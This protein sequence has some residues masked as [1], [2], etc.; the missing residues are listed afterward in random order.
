MELTKR[1]LII[2]VGAMEASSIIIGQQLNWWALPTKYGIGVGF[3]LVL[4][5]TIAYFI[6][7]KWIVK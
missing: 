7:A 2:L 1:V 3:N 5:W 6:T 4:S